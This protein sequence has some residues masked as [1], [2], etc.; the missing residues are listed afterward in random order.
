MPQLLLKL[1]DF[2][3]TGTYLGPPRPLLIHSRMDYGDA[4]DQMPS[5]C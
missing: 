5:W 3:R 1:S 4:A 2:S